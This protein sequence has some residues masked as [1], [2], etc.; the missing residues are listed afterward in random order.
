MKLVTTVLNILQV[1]DA[2]KA[3]HDIHD[4]HA[5]HA[6]DRR[7]R[8]EGVVVTNLKRND[9]ITT[10]S[11]REYIHIHNRFMHGLHFL[12]NRSQLEADSSFGHGAGAAGSIHHSGYSRSSNIHEQND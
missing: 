12:P 11:E 1:R 10:L 2:S 9:P 6:Y 5:V 3:T 7:R 4:I 8:R